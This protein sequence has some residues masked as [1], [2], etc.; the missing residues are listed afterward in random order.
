M[1]GNKIIKITLRELKRIISDSIKELLSEQ[2]THISNFDLKKYFN[3][4][5]IPNY[6]KDSIPLLCRENEIF[7]VIGYGISEKI[8]VENKPSYV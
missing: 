5:K 6:K 3:S 8:K 2:N 1:K 4:K 7:W